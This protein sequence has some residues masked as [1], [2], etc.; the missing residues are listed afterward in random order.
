MKSISYL[1]SIVCLIALVTGCKDDERIR[2]PEFLTGA[3]MRIVVDPLHNQINYQ[4]VSTDF[5]AFDAYSE[6]TDLN[7]VE[8]FA[9]YNGVTRLVATFTQADFSDDG[10]VRVEIDANDFATLF[11][12]PGFA[13]G[14]AGGNFVITPRVTLNDGRVY[15]D[16]VKLSATDSIRNI[17]A[18]V[19][20]SAGNKGAFT[21]QV[22]TAITCTPFDISGNY[23]VV[24]ASGQSTDGCCPGTFTVSG[25]TVVITMT[26]VTTFSVSDIT[27]G[28]YLDWYD[29]YGITA[30]EDTPGNFSF[31]C[32][33]VNIVNSPEPFGTNFSGSGTFD[34]ATGTI[35]YTF[36]NGYADTGTVT[37]MRI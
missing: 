2:I 12:V 23:R 3:N 20:G 5:F 16:F 19:V 7:L 1:I 27:G 29:V 18:G 28:L 8:F 6:N 33:G 14:T 26:S 10:K 35:T 25:N 30:P 9:T 36:S 37:L 15:P 17:G 21:L 13:D 31:N 32:G 34:N 11:G 4:T 24:S 22:V